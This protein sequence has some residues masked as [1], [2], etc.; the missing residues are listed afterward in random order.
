MLLSEI[1][2]LIIE[3]TATALTSVLLC[4]LAKRNIQIIFCDEKH[5]PCFN[6]VPFHGNYESSKRIKQQFNW[7]KSV[8]GLV[9]QEIVKKKISNQAHILKTKN[10]DN[11]ELLMEYVYQVEFY[12]KTNREGHAAKVY[13]NSLFGHGFSRQNKEHPINAALNYGYTL[14]L[15]TITQNIVASGY[16]PQLGIWHDS[17]TN[18]FNFS[19][20]LIEPFRIFVDHCVLIM[21]DLVEF[22]RELNNMFNLKVNIAQQ[23]TTLENALRIYVRSVIKALETSDVKAINFV[24]SYEF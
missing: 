12:D 20:D 22:K 13:F 19:S 18:P 24:K 11:Y 6:C 2:T 4:E 15:S 1:H 17:D 23:T 7:T 10:N 3:N 5:N 14:L 8:K 9:W 21:D 16:L